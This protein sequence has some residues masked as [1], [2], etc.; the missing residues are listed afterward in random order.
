MLLRNQGIQLNIKKLRRLMSIH[1][2][3]TIYPIP[4]TTVID[5]DK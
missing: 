4:R 1:G 2:W 3:Q 5:P